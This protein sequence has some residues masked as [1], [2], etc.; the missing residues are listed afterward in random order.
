MI[1]INKIFVAFICAK[2]VIAIGDNC[3]K[4]CDQDGQ[5]DECLLC[6]QLEQKLFEKFKH[7]QH[8]GKLN[9]IDERVTLKKIGADAEKYNLYLKSN[10]IND[11]LWR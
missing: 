3:R 6:V 8:D 9:T 4:I 7:E 2:I 10:N 11:D 1:G 5:F